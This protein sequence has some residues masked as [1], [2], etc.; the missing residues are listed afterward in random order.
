MLLRRIARPLLAAVS[1]TNGVETLINPKPKIDAATPLLTT[2]PTPGPVDPGLVVQAGAAVKIA[3]GTMLAVG[4]MPR[5]AAT[6]LA[7]EL[8]PS[9]VAEHPFWAGGYPDDRRAHQQHFLKNLG[10]LGGLLLAMT[11]SEPAKKKRRKRR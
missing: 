2:L 11:S 1:I 4:W 5:I 10:L 3:A 9:T 7:V 6:A 8:I